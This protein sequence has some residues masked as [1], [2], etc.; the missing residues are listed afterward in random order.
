MLDLGE[1]VA[2]VLERREW[3]VIV[4]SMAF[5]EGKLPVDGDV[6]SNQLAARIQREAAP[7]GVLSRTLQEMKG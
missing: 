4:M 2:L 5:G 6:V 1:K 3:A 7:V